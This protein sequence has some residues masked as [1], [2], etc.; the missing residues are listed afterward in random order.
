MSSGR[1][2][3]LVVLACAAL[4]AA[5]AGA[6]QYSVGGDNGWAVP[7]AGAESYNTWAEK[8]GFQVGDQ[9]LFVYPKDKD[10]V[11]LVQ[12]ADYNACNTSSYTSSSPTGTPSSTSTAPAPSSSSAA[13]TPTAAPTRSSSSWSP[14]PP[15]EPRARQ[16]RA[17][18]RL[19]RR[20]LPRLTLVP[21]PAS[22][23]LRRRTLQPRPTL[24]PP[25]VTRPR[26]REHLLEH[27]LAALG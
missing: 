11:L 23:H 4:M 27:R 9:L 17:R 21:A 7:G 14:P 22:L 10:S 25:R 19:R 26:P 12:P 8:T 18:A 5:V 20:L 6:T 24:R 13:S 15:P 2:F 3:A 16:R 1:S